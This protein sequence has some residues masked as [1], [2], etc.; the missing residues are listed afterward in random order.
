MNRTTATKTRVIFLES[1]A[2]WE[3]PLQRLRSLSCFSR[4]CSLAPELS[5]E[6]RPALSPLHPAACP[7][8]SLPTP[9]RST[10]PRRQP[11]AQHS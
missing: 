1:S 10:L 9:A 5:L 11:P 3:G 2:E 7:S 6:P 8:E 4:P